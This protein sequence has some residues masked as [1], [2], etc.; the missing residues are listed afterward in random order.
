M[1]KSEIANEQP[2]PKVILLVLLLALL[3]GGN[4]VSIKISLQDLPPLALAG[5]R[6]L[7]GLAA[8]TIWSLSRGIRIRLNPGEMLPLMALTVIFLL[9]II[10]LNVGTGFTTA[11]RSA[12]FIST[13]PFFTALFANF[14]VPGD[15]LFIRKT[16]GIC[17]AF[18]GV[19]L[20]FADNLQL[21]IDGA[22]VGDLI[23]MTSGALLGLR[24]V[25]T[26]RVVQS[27]HPYRLLIWLMIFS[28]P[29][30]FG[31]SF[32]LE[33]DAAFHLSISGTAAILY[34]G[35]VIAG[36]CFVAWTSVLEKYSPSKLVV[37]FF[38]TPLA[39]V[40]LSKL[41]L[42]DEIYLTLIGGAVLVACGIYLVNRR[43]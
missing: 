5:F 19:L 15:R 21:A 26:K 16:V 35:L 17:V 9:Q 22:L 10:T 37:L 14:W 13:Y 31:L 29:C 18:G 38:L 7:L 6:F 42:G 41:L 28:L 12:I 1:K 24:V 11:A 27:I 40:L 8:I 3:W 32:L 30:F 4:S 20:T 25:V 23:V 2:T 36:F 33:R 39:G 34:Q 43:D